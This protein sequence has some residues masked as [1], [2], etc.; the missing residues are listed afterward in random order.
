MIHVPHRGVLL[1]VLVLAAVATVV[2][3]LRTA[4]RAAAASPPQDPQPPSKA[5]KEPPSALDLSGRKRMGKASFY[6]KKFAGRRMADGTRMDPQD[7][8]AA[9]NTLPLGTTARVTNVE[10]G[11][12]AEVTIQDRGPHV[13]GR[14]I[15]LSPSTA[16]EIGLDRRDGIADVEVAPIAV[17]LPDGGVKQGVAA[18]DPETVDKAV[19][20]ESR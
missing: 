7:D 9:S 2:G 3:T 18:D 6:A 16:S 14:I 13:K 11:K 4:E 8:N 12:S 5:V 19:D 15:D 20:D 17:P 1:V 10:T